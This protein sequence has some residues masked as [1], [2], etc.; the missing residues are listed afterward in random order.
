MPCLLRAVLGDLEWPLI[1]G[2]GWGPESSL[3]LQGFRGLSEP[4]V[5]PSPVLSLPSEV[6]MGLSRDTGRSPG[7]PRGHST[8]GTARSR[9]MLGFPIVHTQTCSLLEFTL[10]PMSP[11]GPL[12]SAPTLAPRPPPS[13]SSRGSNQARS[14]APKTLPGCLMSLEKLDSCRLHGSLLDPASVRPPR[15]PHVP[16]WVGLLPAPPNSHLCLCPSILPHPSVRPTT[17]LFDC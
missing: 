4:I 9:D 14:H 6:G 7:H 5:S 16:A 11:K 2:T 13:R 17:S 12:A 8:P 15:H 10:L 1:Q 3:Y